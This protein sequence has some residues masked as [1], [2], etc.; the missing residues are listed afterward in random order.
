MQKHLSLSTG[1]LRGCHRTPVASDW[2][3]FE[4]VARPCALRDP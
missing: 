3:N 1:K 4:C 2:E